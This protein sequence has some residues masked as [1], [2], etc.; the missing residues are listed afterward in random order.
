MSAVRDAFRALQD[1]LKENSG[2][3]G[4]NVVS[5]EP[6]GGIVRFKVAFFRPSPSKP[7]PDAVVFTF[8]VEGPELSFRTENGQ[9]DY[10]TSALSPTGLAEIVE[11]VYNQ[12]MTFLRGMEARERVA[13]P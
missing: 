4:F 11:R 10:D 5:T 3:F 8:T 2:P 9:Y 6:E 7:I 1:Y 12:K 13:Q